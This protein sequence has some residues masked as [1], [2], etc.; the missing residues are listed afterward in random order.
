MSF[1]KYCVIYKEF[2]PTIVLNGSSNLNCTYKT[3]L[4][5]F[6]HLWDPI[7]NQIPTIHTWLP[8]E[9]F[10]IFGIHKLNPNHTYRTSLKS[11]PHFR[12]PQI[13]SQPYIQDF[14]EKLSSSL[15]SNYKSNPN[16]TYKTFLRRFS[17]LWDRF[18]NQISTIQVCSS[19]L[20]LIAE[21][22]FMYF[23]KLYW[24]HF[25]VFHYRA[26]RLEQLDHLRVSSH[27]HHR[28]G[29]LEQLDHLWVSSYFYHRAGRLEQL[30]HLRVSS[31]FIIGLVIWKIGPLLKSLSC[32]SQKHYWNHFHVF[33]KNILEITFMYFTKMLKSLSSISQTGRFTKPLLKSLSCISQ[34]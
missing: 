34:C 13:E 28:A 9:A 4:K 32:I 25:Q 2:T 17:H 27:F 29:R 24:N 11:F 16:R 14:L 19:N 6:P 20:K 22:T 31:H 8:W 21:I 7:T 26:G 15:G 1:V 3:F 10:L 12:D 30:D 5:S 33:H 23:T 18:T